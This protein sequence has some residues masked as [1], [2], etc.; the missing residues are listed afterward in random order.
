VRFSAPAKNVYDVIIIGAGPGG[1][2]A[3]TLLARQ[4]V[5]CLLLDRAQFPREKVCGDGLTPQALYWLERL[6]CADEVLDQAQCCIFGCDLHINGRRI[7]TGRFPQDGAYPGFCTLLP[8]KTLDHILVR[9]AVANGARFIDRCRVASLSYGGDGILVEGETASGRKRFRARLLIGAD[10]AGS[11]VSRFIG[12]SVTAGTKALSM[13]AYYSKVSLRGAQI[14]VF[15]DDYL[16]PGYGWIFADHH[17]VANVGVGCVSDPLFART[18]TVRQVFERFIASSAA[19]FLRG[20]RQTSPRAGGWAAFA[21]L[22]RIVADRIMLIGD[23]ANHTDPVNGGGIH[24]AIEDAV[25]VSGLAVSALRDGDCSFERLK[26][27]EV[28]WEAR[29]GADWRSAEL[30]LA[31]AK[32]PF[33]RSLYL[34]MLE[35]IGIACERS[36]P[37]ADFCVGVF[38]GVSAQSAYLS[39]LKLLSVMPCDPSAWLE[40]S[41]LIRSSVSLGAR[42]ALACLESGREAFKEPWENANWL[43][44][45]GKKLLDVGFFVPPAASADASRCADGW[46]ANPSAGHSRLVSRRNHAY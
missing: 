37:F 40:G 25:L 36:A 23:A 16:F 8:R 21:R 35:R 31:F 9:K 30:L 12:N 18:I 20:A 17:G 32:N 45:V 33:L 46:R 19:E 29:W 27:Y 44:E 7:L 26:S 41:D 39:P 11:M 28:Q 5:S 6:G 43:V 38:S 15:F 42:T 4:G 13:R 1:S 24:K 10:G 22:Q 34:L 3:A 14:K 2:S